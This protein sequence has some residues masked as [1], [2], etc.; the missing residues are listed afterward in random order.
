MSAP[1]CGDNDI[2]EQAM[3]ATDDSRIRSKRWAI[4][5]EWDKNDLTYR[6]STYTAKLPMDIVND[7]VARAFK[8]YT[9]CVSCSG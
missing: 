7:A 9:Q 4:F 3:T 5:Q 2:D 6:I 8:V 1:R